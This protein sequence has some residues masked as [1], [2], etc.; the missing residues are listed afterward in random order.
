M[1]DREA[2]T[3]KERAL[4]ER[5]LK[6][7]YK[8]AFVRSYIEF[9]DGHGGHLAHDLER[10]AVWAG[11]EI[12]AAVAAER[13]RIVAL[14]PLEYHCG[15]CA[16]SPGYPCREMSGGEIAACH[17]ARWTTAILEEEPTDD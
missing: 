8:P 4:R 14:E 16:A 13:E 10:I 2:P 12:R 15:F 7:V 3:P 1:T 5:L 9:M 6:A 17:A 11:K